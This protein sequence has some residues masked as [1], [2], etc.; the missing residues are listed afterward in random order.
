MG[1]G[2]QSVFNMELE[3]DSERNPH[4]IPGQKLLCEHTLKQHLYM[5]VVYT[6]FLTLADV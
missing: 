6:Y 4:P 3:A 1:R 5:H 2:C